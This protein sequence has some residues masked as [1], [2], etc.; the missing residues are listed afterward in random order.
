MILA[1]ILMLLGGYALVTGYDPLLNPRTVMD[2]VY[3]SVHLFGGAAL[4]GV[5]FVIIK[6]DSI[7]EGLKK[8]KDKEKPKSE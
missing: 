6:L 2:Q 1:V 4:L 8:N 3:G 7:L 5:G